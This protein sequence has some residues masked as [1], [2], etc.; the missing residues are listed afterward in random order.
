MYFIIVWYFL[1]LCYMFLNANHLNVYRTLRMDREV[2]TVSLLSNHSLFLVQVGR[3]WRITNIIN[4]CRS[5]GCLW[6][7]LS[8]EHWKLKANMNYVKLYNHI[9]LK[10]K[11]TCVRRF[12]HFFSFYDC[13]KCKQVYVFDEVRPGVSFFF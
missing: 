4:A 6:N 1:N 7:E 9:A 11:F 2:I 10:A 5:D 3:N 12:R 13:Y 8:I